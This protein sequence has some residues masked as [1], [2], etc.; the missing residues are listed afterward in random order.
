MGDGEVLF[1]QCEQ[2][3][4]QYSP[5][6]YRNGLAISVLGKNLEINSELGTKI[7]GAFLHN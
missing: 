1:P 4:E 6:V 7:L 3:L 2:F 5:C